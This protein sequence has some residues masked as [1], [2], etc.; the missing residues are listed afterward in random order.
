MR[1]VGDGVRAKSAKR[2]L[3]TFV[4]TPP[5]LGSPVRKEGAGGPENGPPADV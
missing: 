2:S 1:R 5:G 3:N 4:A